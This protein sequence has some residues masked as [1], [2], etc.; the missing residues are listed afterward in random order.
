M[1]QGTWTTISETGELEVLT[2]NTDKALSYDRMNELEK[3]TDYEFSTKD[4]L[5]ALA[6]DI[7]DE[8]NKTFEN[9]GSSLKITAKTV[10]FLAIGTAAYLAYSTFQKVSHGRA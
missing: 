1:Y 6:D 5:A 9:I 7:S 8:A 10:T 4:K 2:P 3:Y